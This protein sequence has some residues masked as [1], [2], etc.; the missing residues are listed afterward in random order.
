ME[1]RVYPRVEYFGVRCC[2]FIIDFLAMIT[3][4]LCSEGHAQVFEQCF[5]FF[6]GLCRSNKRY[7]EAARLFHLIVDDFGEN[8][9]LANA[10]C[11][12]AA[13]V[14]VGVYATE[15]AYA[16]Q[17]DTYQLVHEGIHTVTA[18]CNLGTYGHTLTYLEVSNGQFAVGDEGFLTGDYFQFL[19]GKLEGLGIV[20]D[21][22]DRS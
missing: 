15:V 8:K 11:V 21:V 3:P 10:E 14:K 5:A 13:S 20:L 6:V 1:Q 4:Q 22:A 2:L 18:K 16:R 19:N 9:L 7:V 12:V 17:G